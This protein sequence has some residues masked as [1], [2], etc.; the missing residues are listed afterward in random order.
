MMQV[1]EWMLTPLEQA[2]PTIFAEV[3]FVGFLA[4]T[5]APPDVVFLTQDQDIFFEFGQSLCHFRTDSFDVIS[6]LTVPI[7]S[8]RTV[9]VL[10]MLTLALREAC[11]IVADFLASI[12]VDINFLQAHQTGLC[13]TQRIGT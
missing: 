1:I 2:K 9:P 10:F 6:T 3:M 5:G 13:K 4:R 12:P 8:T 7:S 11:R